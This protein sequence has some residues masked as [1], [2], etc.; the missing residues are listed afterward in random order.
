MP[1]EP[2]D[3]GAASERSPLLE[4]GINGG[5]VA[6]S[7]PLP[8]EPSTAKLLLI[9]SSIWVGVF[10]AA[11][12]LFSIGDMNAQASLTMRRLD[13]HCDSE[14]P[15]FRLVQLV[16]PLL[17]ARLGIPDCECCAAAPQRTAD[18]HLWAPHRSRHLERLLR[19][20]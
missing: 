1:R 15:H 2:D 18:G 19:R 13:S 20:R 7:P 3:S 5:A 6:D 14:Q 9:L 16:H 12:G 11:L 4:N 10:L 17:M 8:E